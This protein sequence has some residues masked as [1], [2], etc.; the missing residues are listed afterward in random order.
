MSRDAALEAEIQAKGLTAARI[1]PADV[2]AAIASEHYFTAA[3]GAGRASATSVDVG[4]GGTVPI[5]L[6]LMTFCVLVLR[7]G[8]TVHG[9]SAVASPENFNAEIGR[10]VARQKA[11]DEIWTLLGYALKERLNAGPAMLNLEAKLSPEEIATF[12]RDWIQEAGKHPL[13]AVVVPD[14]SLD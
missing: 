8:F 11:V 12:K 3:D 13:H 6:H 7:N 10:K 14:R 5:P 9:V 2:E 4:A 1:R